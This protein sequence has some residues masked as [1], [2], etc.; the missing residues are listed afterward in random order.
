[1]LKLV[2][3]DNSISMP[4]GEVGP[5]MSLHCRVMPV[6]YCKTRIPI[7]R[8]EF[9]GFRMEIEEIPSIIL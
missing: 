8:Y 2:L 1:M 4:V 5:L 9:K 3:D 7:N 6:D